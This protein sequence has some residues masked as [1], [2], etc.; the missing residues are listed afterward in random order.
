M[1]GGRIYDTKRWKH[2]REVILRRDGYMDQLELRAGKK[3]NAQTVHHI[4]PVD[5]Y[6]Q[7]R[8]CSW[9]LISLTNANHELM[10]N[11]V[12]GKL[13]NIGMRLLKEKAEQKGI[14][15][16][17]LTLVIGVPGSGKSTWVKAHMGDGIAYDVDALSAAFRLTTSHAERHE[18]ARRLANSLV[19]GFALNARQFSSNVFIIRTAPTLEEL[20]DIDPDRL[21][22]IRTEHDITRRRDYKAIDLE[23]KYKRIDECVEYAQLNGMSLIEI[24]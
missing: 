14:P 18:G 8:W 4:F 2:L 1:S 5:M 22:V 17:M 11:R 15:V 3:V 23:D 21:V 10:H 20:A 12:T 13:S 9:N 6:P 16:S 24:Q 7:Y 19:R